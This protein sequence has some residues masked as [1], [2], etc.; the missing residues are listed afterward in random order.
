MCL[1][2]VIAAGAFASYFYVAGETKYKGTQS[3]FDKKL[4]FMSIF[5]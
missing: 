3:V 5:V 4:N 2:L 1:M